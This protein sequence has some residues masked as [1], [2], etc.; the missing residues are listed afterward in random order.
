[1]RKEQ[2]G[3]CLPELYFILFDILV[4]TNSTFSAGDRIDRIGN[5]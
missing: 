2:V 1:M 3:I 4:I 5:W